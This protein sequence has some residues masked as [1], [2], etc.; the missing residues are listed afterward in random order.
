MEYEKVNTLCPR[1]TLGYETSTEDEINGQLTRSIQGTDCTNK[2]PVLDQQ[3]PP[4]ANRTSLS[5]VSRFPDAGNLVQTYS[6]SLKPNM[7]EHERRRH[8]CGT[9]MNRVF[10]RNEHP[11][12]TLE[13][14]LRSCR[15]RLYE[16]YNLRSKCEHGRGPLDGNR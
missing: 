14:N 8:L 5:V 7:S 10:I 13:K 12:V 2:Y 6:V 15:L 11:E 9:L 16:N 1:Q 4:F 3:G